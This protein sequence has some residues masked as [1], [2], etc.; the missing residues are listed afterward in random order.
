MC[1]NVTCVNVSV[2][3]ANVTCV[4]VSVK[5]ANVTCVNVKC[6]NVTV[7]Q[8]QAMSILQDDHSGRGRLHD[9]SGT[10]ESLMIRLHDQSGTGE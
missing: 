1:G 8:W 6:A 4:N 3:C 10:G 7:L 5:C 9:Q 2:K